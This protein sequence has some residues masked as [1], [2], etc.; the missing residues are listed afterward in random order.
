M[1]IFGLSCPAMSSVVDV[2]SVMGSERLNEP[3]FFNVVAQLPLGEEDIW[4][5][6]LGQRATLSIRYADSSA[7]LCHGIV[8]SHVVVGR[9]PQGR[10]LVELRLAPRFASMSLRQDSRIF[11]DLTVQ[12]IC[13]LV[14]A[15]HRVKCQWRT[16]RSYQARDYCVQYQESDQQFVRR[17]LAEEGILFWFEHHDTGGQTVQG[18][19]V[20]VLADDANHYGRVIGD[21]TLLYREHAGEESGLRIEERQVF[22]FRAATALTSS[23]VALRDYDFRR[24]LLELSA[25]TGADA[26]TGTRLEVYDHHA[27]YGETDVGAEHA[28]V[29]LEQL[30]SKRRSAEGTTLCRRLSPGLGFTLAEHPVTSLDGEWIVTDVEHEGRI[31]DADATQTYRA[32]FRAVPAGVCY[33]PSRPAR[34]LR[35]TQETAIV[36]GPPGHELHVD[37][38]GRI[39]VQFHWDRRGRRDQFSSCW[40]RVAQ[41]WAGNGWGHQFIPRVGMEVL[42]SFLGGDQDRPVVTGAVYNAVNPPMEALPA[43]ATRS[44]IRTRSTPGG[45]GSNEISFEDLTGSE[46]FLVNAARDYQEDVA[47]DRRAT[48]GRND[49]REVGGDLQ[50]NVQGREVHVVRGG[51]TTRISGDDA[52]FVEG[53]TGVELRGAA[54]VTVQGPLS[55]QLMGSES[56]QVRGDSARRVFGDETRSVAGAMEQAVDGDAASTVGGN[57]K[58]TVD[59]VATLNATD[60]L[61]VS[62]GTLREPK[63]TNLMLSGGAAL[64]AAG[65]MGFRSQ[66]E[67]RI[68]VGK[69]R[70]V[71]DKD[72]LRIEAK[73]IELTADAILLNGGGAGLALTGDA[74]LSGATVKVSSAGGAVLE[75]DGVAKLDGPAVHLRPGAAAE[76]AARAKREE[77]AKNVEKES[78]VLYDRAGDPITEGPYEVSLPGYLDAGIAANG[79]IEIP[80]FPDVERCTIR[81]S[82]S[83]AARGKLPPNAPVYEFASELYLQVD[84]PD[85]DESLRRKLVNLGFDERTLARSPPFSS[86]TAA[87]PQESPTT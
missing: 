59:G 14:L 40:V 12:Q 34:V 68:E 9:A 25:G 55:T 7:R 1:N 79:S 51:R 45:G 35:Q 27:E 22:A 13:D 48:V 63:P 54:N 6:V 83:A 15:E 81:W 50:T 47:V 87:S 80:K 41:A 72:G 33:R 11:Q 56:I 36:V 10:A 3:Y 32:R 42:V 76:S 86:R 21:P 77:Q 82:R 43:R 62:V 49:S 64:D 78:I 69:N 70:L 74:K 60:G 23:A 65:G 38:L 19:E 57:A 37:P 16:Q 17:I 18:E 26:E 4:Q 52:L 39:K 53:G 67:V 30:Q 31:G 2:V 28:R 24:P 66:D 71:L 73:R 5:S 44:G 58:L 20:L 75:L 29:Y 8:T 46:M 61:T 85:P 84:H